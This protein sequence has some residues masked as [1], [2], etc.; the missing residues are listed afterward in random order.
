MTEPKKRGA[1]RRRA[2]RAARVATLGL[3]LA[4][5]GC[6]AAH[7]A[8]GEADPEVRTAA[9]EDAAVVADAEAPARDGGVDAAVAD[10]G[11]CV[12]GDAGW[13]AY[14]ECCDAIGW[15]WE[16]G[17]AAWGPFVPPADGEVA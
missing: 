1:H 9:T 3:V 13:E 16:R 14:Q 10:A 8:P 15:D 6:Y 2:L 7:D 17:C 11:F 5:P 12:V 4:A